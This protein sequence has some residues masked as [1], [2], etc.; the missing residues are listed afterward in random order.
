MVFLLWH[1]DRIRY[2]VTIKMKVNSEMSK[3]GG[4]SDREQQIQGPSQDR[5]VINCA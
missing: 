5:A 4:V 3:S 2:S 1:L